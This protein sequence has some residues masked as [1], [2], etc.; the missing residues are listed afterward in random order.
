MAREKIG[1]LIMLLFSV[2]YGLLATQITL[3]FLAQQETFTSR[4]MPVW[5]F[6]HRHP[7][8]AGNPG[9]AHHGRSG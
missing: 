7:D 1:A 6:H 2:A 8:L 3:T 5:A 9:S 4:T